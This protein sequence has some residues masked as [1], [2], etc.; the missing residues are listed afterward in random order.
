MNNWNIKMNII[1]TIRNRY[2]K[3]EFCSTFVQG[4][5]QRDNNGTCYGSQLN[6][7]PEN[8]IMRSLF[9][10]YAQ[11]IDARR[12]THHMMP[13]GDLVVVFLHLYY[14][15][16]SSKFESSDFF[17]MAEIEFFNKGY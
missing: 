11:V 9:S 14:I 7:S 6:N 4:T 3:R 10:S 15:I 1:F 5:M 12:F 13:D 8:L 16:V 2:V 17:L